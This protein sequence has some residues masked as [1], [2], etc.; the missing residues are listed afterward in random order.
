MTRGARGRGF[1]PGACTTRVSR[2][3]MNVSVDGVSGPVCVLDGLG[4][5]STGEGLFPNGRGVVT[6]HTHDVA[7]EF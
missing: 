1:G 3:Q 5:L 6:V 4:W 2:S 7:I